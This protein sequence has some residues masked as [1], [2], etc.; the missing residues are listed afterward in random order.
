M[1]MKEAE[2]NSE[3]LQIISEAIVEISTAIQAGAQAD[4]GKEI[5]TIQDGLSLPAS[6]SRVVVLLLLISRRKTT[7][8]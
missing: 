5:I 6:H 4:Q 1:K 8:H 7:S 2:A 3:S